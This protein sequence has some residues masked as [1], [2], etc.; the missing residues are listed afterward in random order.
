MKG[1]LQSIELEKQEKRKK[2]IQEL[3]LEHRK[4]TNLLLMLKRGKMTMLEKLEILL[5]A[6]SLILN[7]LQKEEKSIYPSII[8]KGTKQFS[9][10]SEFAKDISQLSVGILEFFDNFE[11]MI[12]EKNADYPKGFGSLL[13]LLTT[14]IRREESILYPE[15]LKD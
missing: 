3:E 4:I 8:K 5:R 11:N 9:I 14:R 2:L 12:Q 10:A 7:H 1:L 15:Y 13:V 6:K